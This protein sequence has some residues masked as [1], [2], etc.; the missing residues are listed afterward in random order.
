MLKQLRALAADLSLVSTS[1]ASMLTS[2]SW[3]FASTVAH[4]AITRSS[5]HAHLMSTNQHV[6]WTGACRPLGHLPCGCMCRWSCGCA[7]R[8]C[9]QLPYI[10]PRC[11]GVAAEH[12][13]HNCRR[14][15]YRPGLR[16]AC[17]LA[18][19]ASLQA[20]DS[21]TASCHAAALPGAQDRRGL[22]CTV[23]N[24]TV[25]RGQMGEGWCS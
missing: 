9:G 16:L 1:L 4:P 8:T 20:G 24:H 13:A 17:A 19:V 15:G 2:I 18:M 23:H 25:D 6:A 7:C 21:F 10:H 5:A 11:R 3:A 14:N 22:P 12:H